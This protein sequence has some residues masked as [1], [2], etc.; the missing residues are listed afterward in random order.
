MTRPVSKIVSGPSAPPISLDEAKKQARIYHDDDDDEVES[1]VLAATAS[2]EQYLQRK[3]I[4]QRWRMYLDYWSAEIHI[5]FGDL[6]SLDSF[7]YTDDSGTQEDVD[8]SIYS[9]DTISAPGRII[10]NTSESWPV[11]TLGNNNPIEVTF[12][13]G[14]GTETSS[15][16]QDIR[17]A[18]LLMFSQLYSYR[19]SVVMNNKM[20]IDEISFDWKA[21]L[22]NHR[23]W[24][25]AL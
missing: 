17:H 24:K 16:P 18:I 3:L 15:V 13:T 19:E 9:T 5:L 1:M 14:Y 12:T 23:V 8:S 20:N 6:I 22:Y 10:L 7:K 4:S 2:V 21:M 11:V 25:W